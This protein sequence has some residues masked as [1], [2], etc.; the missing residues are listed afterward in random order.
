M[1]V[2][3]LVVVVDA[4]VVVVVVEALVVVVEALVVV[5]VATP[6]APAHEPLQSFVAGVAP[7]KNE[8]GMVG[9]AIETVRPSP[10]LRSPA[11][12]GAE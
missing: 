5:V 3:A 6:E 12:V 11:M 1:V 4:L 10:A 8:L 7:G 2:A 9:I